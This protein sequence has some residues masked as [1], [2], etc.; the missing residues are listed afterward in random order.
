MH[1]MLMKKLSCGVSLAAIA[2]FAAT[3]VYAQETTGG[4]RGQVLDQSGAPIAGATVTITHVPSGTS[5]TTVSG[6]D[7]S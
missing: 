2:T 6:A 3:A 4:I 5:N 7:G 1:F